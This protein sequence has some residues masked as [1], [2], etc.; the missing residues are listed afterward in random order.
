[1]E[2][3]TNQVSRNR[4]LNSGLSKNKTTLTSFIPQSPQ[5]ITAGIHSVMAKSVLIHSRKITVISPTENR[6]SEKIKAIWKHSAL[7]KGPKNS[8]LRV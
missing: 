3:S 7:E 1:M 4:A 5:T 8:A 2:T 6:Q